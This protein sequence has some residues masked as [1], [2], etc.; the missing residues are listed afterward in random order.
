MLSLGRYLVNWILCQSFRSMLLRA[1]SRFWSSLIAAFV[2]DLT[3][4]SDFIRSCLGGFRTISRLG[5]ESYWN[6]SIQQD[7]SFLQYIEKTQ[8]N[9]QVPHYDFS[10]EFFVRYAGSLHENIGS[11]P[12]TILALQSTFE[13]IM[14][15]FVTLAL[16]TFNCSMGSIT[17]TVAR[18][19]FTLREFRA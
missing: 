5:G 1:D 6:C 4:L 12:S 10:G 9:S 13:V 8:F 3:P 17:G 2:A 7:H 14:E 11:L 15:Q 18:S 16:P 19:P